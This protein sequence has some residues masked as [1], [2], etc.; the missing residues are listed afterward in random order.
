MAD[1]QPHKTTAGSNGKYLHDG[2]QCPQEHAKQVVVILPVLSFFL[3]A[4]ANY[5]LFPVLP[6]PLHTVMEWTAP[7]LTN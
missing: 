5:Q 6:N 3:A 7:S 4:N 1:L 2:K